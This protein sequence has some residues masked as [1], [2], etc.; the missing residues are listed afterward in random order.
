VTSEA[1]KVR[2]SRLQSAVPVILVVNSGIGAIRMDEPLWTLRGPIFAM[3]I[4]K[5][6]LLRANC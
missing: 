3:K 2:G 4:G 1:V 6:H 5:N